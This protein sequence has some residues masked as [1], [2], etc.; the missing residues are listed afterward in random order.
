MA[1]KRFVI[2]FILCYKRLC[3]CFVP[4][5]CIVFVQKIDIVITKNVHLAAMSSLERF[6]YVLHVKNDTPLLAYSELENIRRLTI[7][8][9]DTNT[10]VSPVLITFVALILMYGRTQVEIGDLSSFMI[11]RSLLCA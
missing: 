6:S 3:Q 5:S 1:Q 7:S 10:V 9:Q 8:V 2:V 11:D 4:R